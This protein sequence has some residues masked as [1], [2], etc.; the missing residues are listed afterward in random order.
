M[1]YVALPRCV[2]CR[3]YGDNAYLFNRQNW[4]SAFVRDVAAFRNFFSRHPVDVQREI[5]RI[6]EEC[7]LADGAVEADFHEVFDPLISDG[8]FVTGDRVV[9]A[10]DSPLP[11][12]TVSSLNSSPENS[13]ADAST[14]SADEHYEDAT[15]S[16]CRYFEAHP[17]PFELC[18]DLTQ[19]CTER[20]VHCYVPEFKPV[21]LD[22]ELAKKVIGEFVAAGGLK[23]KLTGG[24]CMTHS[25]F[26]EIL[27]L[28]TASDM[29]VS[30]LSNLTLCDDAMAEH[31]AS[32]GVAI[33]QTSLYGARP[34]THEEITR[35]KG[36]FLETVSGIDRLLAHGVP[37][38]I[39]CPVM[40]ANL[41]DVDAIRAFARARNIKVSFDPS[42]MCRADHDAGNQSYCLDERELEEYLRRTIDS[43]E[44]VEESVDRQMLVDKRVCEI[45]ISK[46]CLAASG[47]YYP[48]NG[49][50]GY[51][52]GDCRKMSITEVWQGEA[53]RHLRGLTF[54]DLDRCRTCENLLYCKA[55]PS[56]NFNA[57]GSL[58]EP[59]LA[60]CRLAALRRKVC[61]EGGCVC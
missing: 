11:C 37:V 21:A 59:D 34:E 12:A 4:A 26:K 17:M 57:T 47:I 56:R 54:R 30:V 50:Y 16:L 29:V 41:G 61:C 25:A 52:L 3:I 33:V 8:Y 10:D 58:A 49:C 27:L 60:A 18:I 39:N 23:V 36:S 13:I 43:D 14:D 31:I 6:A 2:Y 7:E 40:K 45:G 46:V 48:C 5:H 53:M 32:C 15:A 1:N 35:R 38:Q 22:V 19:S 44:K 28:A 20:C 55:C 51:H 42:I 9:R 24:E